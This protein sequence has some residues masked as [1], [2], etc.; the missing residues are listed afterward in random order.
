MLKKYFQQNKF[1]L[2]SQKIEE[3]SWGQG[4]LSSLKKLGIY[5]NLLV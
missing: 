1:T 5:I 4:Q 2:W 3:I